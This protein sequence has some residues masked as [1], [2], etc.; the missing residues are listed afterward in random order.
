MCYVHCMD[1]THGGK[2]IAMRYGGWRRHHVKIGLDMQYG[3]TYIGQHAGT[4]LQIALRGRPV[5]HYHNRHTSAGYGHM[6]RY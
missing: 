6:P 3:M 2:A 1:Y 5:P 4:L